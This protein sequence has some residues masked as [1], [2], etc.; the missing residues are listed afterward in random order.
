MKEG[1]IL[2]IVDSLLFQSRSLTVV[3]ILQ[4]YKLEINMK[5]D[6]IVIAFVVNDFFSI[7]VQY[8][9]NEH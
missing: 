5:Y 4:L 3:S 2:L 9:V 6:D 7:G 8:P 1:H